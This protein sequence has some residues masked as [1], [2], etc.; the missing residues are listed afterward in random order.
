MV[1]YVCQVITLITYDNDYLITWLPVRIISIHFL[2][3]KINS[4]LPSFW[5][6][7]QFHISSLMSPDSWCMY[8][9]LWQMWSQCSDLFLPTF[10]WQEKM[11]PHPSPERVEKVA[12]SESMAEAT[13][14]DGGFQAVK[15]SKIV[16]DLKRNI[17]WTGLFLVFLEDFGRNQRMW[18]SIHFNPFETPFHRLAWWKVF[19]H[20][21]CLT[22]F[23]LLYQLVRTCC[24][25]KSRVWNGYIRTW[26]PLKTPKDTSCLMNLQQHSK[27]GLFVYTQTEY[28]STPGRL[29]KCKVQ[30]FVQLDG[31]FGEFQAVKRNEIETRSRQCAQNDWPYIGL[32]NWV[33]KKNISYLRPSEFSAIVT[34]VI[35]QVAFLGETRSRV[36]EDESRGANT[37]HVAGIW[38]FLLIHV[39]MYWWYCVLR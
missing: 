28:T 27:F 3:N 26:N 25:S 23:F 1:H 39:A 2:Y 17:W 31:R 19:Q 12:D 22:C 37:P 10:L 33:T 21:K 32:Q 8:V 15:S 18:V 6:A 29:C 30:F 4:P 38:D 11:Q 24:L 20:C 16:L 14:Q 5:E 13:M 36:L 35:P 7:W 9:F 34:R